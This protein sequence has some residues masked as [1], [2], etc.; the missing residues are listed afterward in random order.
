M[1]GVRASE[2]GAT[3][4]GRETVSHRCGL[5]ALISGSAGV[6]HFLRH[7]EGASTR[8]AALALVGWAYCQSVRYPSSLANKLCYNWPSLGAG[9][10][11]GKT[12]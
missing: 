4:M 1:E 6:G 10:V 7:A 12:G 2:P 5:V 3:V 11:F 9:R 8:L